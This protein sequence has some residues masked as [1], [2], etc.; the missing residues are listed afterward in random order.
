MLWH[1]PLTFASKS[2]GFGICSEISMYF[3]D[4][5][6]F[7]CSSRV[8]RGGMYIGSRVCLFDMSFKVETA[9]AVKFGSFED[10]YVKKVTSVVDCTHVTFMD[11]CV[12]LQSATYWFSSFSEPSQMRKVSSMKRYHV[13][14]L[15]GGA[16]V[17]VPTKGRQ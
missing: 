2:H 16:S 5:D 8:V 13:T 9:Y 10:C 7:V 3:A 12:V 1:G 15:P 4:N 14:I 11:S 17:R 6:A